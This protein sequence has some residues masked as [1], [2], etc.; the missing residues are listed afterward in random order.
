M[1]GSSQI[2]AIRAGSLFDG[3][4]ALGPGM[5]LTQ[6]GLITGI[7]TSGAPPPAD[8]LI[9]D[10]GDG[11]T[12]MP[13]LIDCHV[14]LSLDAGDQA[15]LRQHHAWAQSPLAVEQASGSNCQYL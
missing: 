15:C 4:R 7:D 3:E 5:V 2:L 9:H 8:W 1:T 13:G 10:F 6:G 11:V 12:V 14:H